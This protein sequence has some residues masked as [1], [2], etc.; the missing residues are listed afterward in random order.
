MALDETPATQGNLLS[1]LMRTT[2]AL[3][4]LDSDRRLLAGAVSPDGRLMATGDDRGRVTVYDAAS[5]VALGKPYVI[6]EG[7]IQHLRFSPDGGT[8]AVGS[9]DPVEQTQAAVVDLIDPRTRKRRLR[10]ELPAIPERA[11]FVVANV[12]FLADSREVVVALIHGDFPDA[13]PSVL[14]RVDGETGAVESELRIGNSSALLPSATT[15]W[16]AT[17]RHQCR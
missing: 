9:L 11:P 6:R 14:Y 5:R 12:V 8:L 7:V 16:R 4:V 17:L 13:P 10:V 2:A 1:V 15:R 3:G